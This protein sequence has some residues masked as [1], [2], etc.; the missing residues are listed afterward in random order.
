[1]IFQMWASPL[2]NI[3]IYRCI[4]DKFWTDSWREILFDLK[5][6][7][8]NLRMSYQIPMVWIVNKTYK[9]MTQVV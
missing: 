9:Q 1:M 6:I 7:N 3:T 8:V 2:Q 5:K 4:D